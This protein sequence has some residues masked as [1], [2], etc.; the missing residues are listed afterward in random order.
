VHLLSS[1]N[2]RPA[3]TDTLRHKERDD[4]TTDSSIEYDKD[5]CTS[6]RAASLIT[7]KP[8]RGQLHSIQAQRL[9]IENKQAAGRAN[10]RAPVINKTIT[11][12]AS[13]Q[14][15]ILELSIEES[16]AL[17]AKL[18]LAPLRINKDMASTSN[19][20]HTD[21][22]TNGES[23]PSSATTEGTLVSDT[24]EETILEMSVDESNA[25][26]AKLGLP[27]LRTFQSSKVVH[28]PPTLGASI[29]AERIAQ[30][31][32]QREVQRGIQTTFNAKPLGEEDSN[33]QTWAERMRQQKVAI[34]SDASE[35]NK[36]KSS[37]KKKMAA[38]A[39]GLVVKHSVQDFSE[40]STTILTLEDKSLLQRKDDHSHKIIG[41]ADEEEIGLENANM[42][43]VKKQ[44]E[45][46]R[47]KRKY[48][49]G[50]GHAGG[51]AGYDDDEFE[52][53]GGTQAALGAVG[54]REIGSGGGG[55]SKKKSSKSKGFKLKSGTFAAASAIQDEEGGGSDL[56][57]GLSQRAVSL[58]TAGGDTIASDVMTREEMEALRESKKKKKDKKERTK[59]EKESKFKKSNRKEKMKKSRRTVDSDDED[60]GDGEENQLGERKE[61]IQQS[62]LIPEKAKSQ[63]YT[64]EGVRST[65]EPLAETSGFVEVNDEMDAKAANGA[66]EDK[67]MVDY[68]EKES[69]EELI[70]KR[71]KYEAAMAKGNQRSQSVFQSLKKRS[72]PSIRSE[73]LEEEEVDD[74]VMNAALAKAR[75][76]NRLKELAEQK[77][78]HEAGKLKGAD[79]VLDDLT[80]SRTLQGDSDR[81]NAMAGK[82]KTITF[83]IDETREFT[84]AL[85]AKSEQV[86]RSKAK[87]PVVCKDG[88]SGATKQTSVP[89]ESMVV[90]TVVADE[91]ENGGDEKD[92]D[93][94]VKMEDLAREIKEEPMDAGEVLDGNHARNVPIGRGLGGVL[95]MLK[96]TGEITRKNAG[97]EE[98]RGRARDERNYDDYEPL[99]LSK[100][101]KIDEHAA[102]EK[103]REV[104]HREVK[105]EYRDKHGRLLT[106][107]EA[108]RDLCY[109]FHGYGSGKRKEEKKLQQ[110]ARERAETRLASEQ[111]A[112]TGLLGALRKTQEASGKAFI[113][114]K[115]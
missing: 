70:E 16:N 48:E 31:R 61:R 20:S 87:K 17:R 110:I 93:D 58:V 101:V 60:D 51:Y 18:G 45:G 64:T 50:L 73:M 41:L 75:R 99:D 40:G 95:S 105:L 46:L 22:I 68:N 29:V 37:S 109:Q 72:T 62:V 81:N 59:K 83:A 43:D 54:G 103:D 94:D 25:L 88:E 56:F 82:Q 91:T 24:K 86:D 53:L 77:D 32:L 36:D 66:S 100:V 38:D 78:K 8:W 84:R 97:R 57:A 111:G 7:Y 13:T 10:K 19:K 108:F 89:T 85:Q 76:L 28:A 98:L 35:N 2:D 15:K 74:V 115:T 27:P 1:H 30:A 80:Q 6:S 69:A 11:M 42:V 92:S 3:L 52:E 39:E 34:A 26:R 112:E 67:V 113:V 14:E 107:K 65:D 9:R 47:K 71:L 33:V 55:G 96:E 63:V 4:T 102:T 23:Q 49:A 21:T 12:S 114:H 104:A 5:Y 90:T 106:R 44:Q 79:A